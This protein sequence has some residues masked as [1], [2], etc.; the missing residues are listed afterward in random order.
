[1]ELLELRLLLRIAEYRLD[2][3]ELVGCPDDMLSEEIELLVRGDW[4]F[5]TCE[6]CQWFMGTFRCPCNAYEDDL[7]LTERDSN[8]WN[9]EEGVKRLL[10]EAVTKRVNELQYYLETEEYPDW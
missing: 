3:T 10:R 7:S 1:M 4:N 6:S 9:D 5:F 8:K 2:N